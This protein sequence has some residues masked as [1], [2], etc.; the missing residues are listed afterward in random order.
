[1]DHWIDAV[2]KRPGM[3]LGGTGHEG[4]EVALFEVIGNSLDQVLANAGTRIA[5]SLSATGAFE[6]E[7]D[8]AGIR[9]DREREV[10]RPFLEVV[11]TSISNEPTVDGHHPHVHV[12]PRLSGLGLGPICAVARRVEVS[13]HRNGHRYTA[14]FERGRTV[15]ALVD[16][17]PSQGRGTKVRYL[18]DPEIFGSVTCDSV[19][20]RARLAELAWL[21]PRTNWSLDGES[22]TQASGLEAALL[23]VAEGG[24][25]PGTLVTITGESGG[26][27]FECVAGLLATPGLTG[28]KPVVS[29]YANYAPT[30]EGGSHVEGLI[31]GLRRAFPKAPIGRHLVA[32]LHVRL[33]APHFEGP[34]KSRLRVNE[35]EAMVRQVVSEVMLEHSDERIS[36]LEV[37]TR[38]ALGR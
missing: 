26:M 16:H 21:T 6:V 3:Y 29:S 34:T 35:S 4:L 22:L 31:A 15:E 11:F 20:V 7:D 28:R 24:I 14:A 27:D 2:R 19:S 9:V 25:A 38:T 30:N 8:G 17:G 12:T 36:W 32:V 33:L 10:D 23:H 13:T 37:L 5:V 1:V 18:P